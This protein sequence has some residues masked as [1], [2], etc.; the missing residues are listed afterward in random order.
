MQINQRERIMNPIYTPKGK[1]AEYGDY[2]LN[3][4]TG[5]PHRCFYCYAPKVLHKDKEAFHLHVQPRKNSV[6][7]KSVIIIRTKRK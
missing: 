7:F 4:Y 6:F 3:I 2:A 5:C 1:A